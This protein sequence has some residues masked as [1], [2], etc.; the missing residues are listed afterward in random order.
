[1]GHDV[2][3]ETGSAAAEP[4]RRPAVEDWNP[5]GLL[6]KGTVPHHAV[7]DVLPTRRP[8]ALVGRRELELYRALADAGKPPHQR[9]RGADDPGGRPRGARRGV[10]GGPG[11][12]GPGGPRGLGPAPGLVRG[13][14]RWPPPRVRVRRE[15]RGPTRSC[16]GPGRAPD[17]PTRPRPAEPQLA[18]QHATNHPTMGPDGQ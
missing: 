17:T 5:V 9:N 6:P 16:P 10:P 7:L 8:I 11:G 18:G 1:M 13:G 15:R 4:D 3:A 12:F 14:A 2:L